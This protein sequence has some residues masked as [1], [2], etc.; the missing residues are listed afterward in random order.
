MKKAKNSQGNALVI[1]LAVVAVLV[2]GYILVSR[3][4]VPSIVGKVVNTVI[5]TSVTSLNFDSAK[6][7]PVSQDLSNNKG[8]VLQI[9]SN[10]GEISLDG[11]SQGDILTGEIKYLGE[12]TT[13]DYQTDQDEAAIF[14]I[15]SGDQSGAGEN[16]IL[17]LSQLTNG[18]IDIGLGAGS[19]DI[20][21]TDLDIPILNIGAGAGVLDVTFSKNAS[22]IANLAAGAG[23]LNLS[24]YKGTGVK[25]RLTQGISNA[26]FGD[27]YEKV[28]DAYQTKNYSDAKVKVELNIGQAVGGLNIQEIE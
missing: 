8:M 2:V 4:V 23:K 12:K 3:F 16:I 25:I 5:D 26:N 24:I 19:V 22:T 20:D 14:N 28:G 21:L 15:K 13:F 6:S 18:R 11:R 10:R 27:A 17:H 7:Y 9:S 1:I